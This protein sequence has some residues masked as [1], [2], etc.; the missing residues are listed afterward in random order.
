LNEKRKDEKLAEGIVVE[1]LTK[2]ETDSE[3]TAFQSQ[4]NLGK[5]IG[6]EKDFCRRT[7]IGDLLTR[8]HVPKV[9]KNLLR[10]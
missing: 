3:H 9:Y 2:R 10:L 4:L 8:R 5:G 7:G 6:S 1:G